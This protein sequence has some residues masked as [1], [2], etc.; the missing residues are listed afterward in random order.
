MQQKSL[1]LPGLQ[2]IKSVPVDIMLEFPEVQGSLPNTLNPQAKD[3]NIVGCILG[4]HVRLNQAR[5][6]GFWAWGLRV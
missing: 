6:W 4:T 3:S 2:V 1:F 5:A